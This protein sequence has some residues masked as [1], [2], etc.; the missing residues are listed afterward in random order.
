MEVVNTTPSACRVSAHANKWLR[1]FSQ[2]QPSAAE[3]R[4]ALEK[5]LQ[6]KL[7]HARASI[8][9]SWIASVNVRCK[10]DGAE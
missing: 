4:T 10:A 1:N 7:D 6:S 3:G 9:Q 2:H 8:A 5:Q